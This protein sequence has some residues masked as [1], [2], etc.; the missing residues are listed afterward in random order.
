MQTT[1]QGQKEKT[2]MDE[3]TKLH[4]TEEIERKEKSQK[5]L[6]ATSQERLVKFG[7][8]R[9]DYISADAESRGR[10]LFCEIERGKCERE[11]LK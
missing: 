6:V 8:G 1:S 4:V 11:R 7:Q 2:S 9:E 10:E 5:I 3:A